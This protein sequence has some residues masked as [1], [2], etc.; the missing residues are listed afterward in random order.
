MLANSCSL[1]V[2][3]KG[4]SQKGKEDLNVVIDI[5]DLLS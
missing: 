2:K 3:K 1:P 4:V 5:K